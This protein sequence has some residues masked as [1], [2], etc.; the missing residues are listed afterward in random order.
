[1]PAGLDAV[2]AVGGG[3]HA[4][5][6]PQRGRHRVLDALLRTC[7]RCARCRAWWRRSAGTGSAARPT[8]RRASC[9]RTSP[10]TRT[11]SARSTRTGASTRRC[12][13]TSAS[14]AT[15]RWSA[16]PRSTKMG[17]KVGDVVT[18]QSTVF[19]VT[20][21]F[22]IVGAIPRPQNGRFYFQ[23]EYLAQALAAAGRPVRHDRHDLVAHRRSRA[24][25]RRSCARST[26]CS[27]TARRSPRPR[28]RRASSGTSSAACSQLVTIIQ[29]VAGLVTLCIVFI[30]ANTASMSI[31]ERVGE[32]AILKA[33][34]FRKQTIFSTLLAEAGLLALVAGIAGAG[35]ACVLTKMLQQYASSAGPQLGPL[36]AFIVTSAILVQAIFIAFFIGILVRLGA[37][38]RRL[39]AQRRA[40]PARGL[41]ADGAAAL[42]QLAQHARARHAHGLHGR[43]DRPGGD[44]D[45]ALLEPDREP[46]A[47]ADLVGLARQ[48]GRDAQ[49][50]D[51]RRLEPALARGLPGDPLLRGNRQGPGRQPA[52]LA[53]ARRAAVLPHQR[54]A[55]ARTCSCAASSRRRSPCTTRSRSREGRMFDAVERRGRRR[56]DRLASA[57][58]AR[59]SA[60]S[61]ASGTRDWKVVGI[62]D[63]GGSSFESEVWVDAR[64]LANNAKRPLPYS[65]FRIRVA[66]GADMDA[67]ARR[68]GDDQRW[69]L[70][71]TPEIEY[72]RAP[73][74]HGEHAL[75]HRGRARGAGGHRRD[76]RRDQHACTR[77]CRRAPPRSAP[78]ARSASRA[79]R[80]SCA[81]LAESHDD[82]ALRV[83]DRRRC[84]RGSSRSRSRP[85]WAGSAS[86]PRPSRPTSWSCASRPQDL[87]HRRS[88]SRS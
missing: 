5:L 31:R 87:V 60:T 3:E 83:R 26:R 35:T 18:L 38:A 46:E 24:R 2:L 41:L 45:D 78:C 80:S 40:D 43:R 57:T 39:A 61:S 49:G 7:R 30:A 20:L 37:R 82:G 6:D 4:H 23:R 28:P 56:P 12:S 53:R 66:D 36:T 33:I 44:R 51:Q 15:R 47:H 67:L 52:G 21:S 58:R 17:W 63:S 50:R 22:R 34:G 10:S 73:L 27:T 74:V 11:A 65:G 64:E 86:P 55:P 88:C 85:R 68:I 13:R 14:T 71:A 19:P 1:M 9:S 69:A 54:A 8:S 72:Y 62:L 16:R 48:P 79:A 32:I 70:E 75:H 84:C 59:S 81:F 42:V 25:R 76:V 77:R 29:I